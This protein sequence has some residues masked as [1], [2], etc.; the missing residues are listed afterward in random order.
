[1]IDQYEPSGGLEDIC[2][3][4]NDSKELLKY[5]EKSEFCKVYYIFDS[6]KKDII[7]K[8]YKM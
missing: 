4:S 5:E 7:Y 6:E 2:K 3:T 8:N 1:M